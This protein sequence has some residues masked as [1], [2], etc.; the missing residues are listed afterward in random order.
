MNGDSTLLL[1]VGAFAGVASAFLYT[2]ANV[3]LK[4]A[5]AIDP[6]LVAAVKAL[7]T[8]ICLAPVVVWYLVA[9]KPLGTNYS[10]VPRFMVV[11]LIGQFVGNAAFQIAL[12]HIALAVAVP[13]TL[14][15]L[16]IGGGGL[17]WILLGE[18][19]SRG[20]WV[21]MAILILAVVVLSLGDS[22]GDG[23][24]E[25][26][27]QTTTQT[28]AQT[29]PQTTEQIGVQ[30]TVQTGDQATDQTGEPI[31]WFGALCAVATGAAYSLFGVVTRRTLNSGLSMPATLMISG[32]IGV[33]SLWSFCLWRLGFESVV[34][35]EN[36]QWI[37]MA[38]AGG[39]NFAAFVALSASLKY[40]PVVAVNL[41]NA[42][43]VAMAA[44]AGVYF[45]E[46]VITASVVSGITLTVVGLLVL[47][48]SGMRKQAIEPQVFTAEQKP[49]T[50]QKFAAR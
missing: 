44:A 34:A 11:A 31:P 2:A 28:T 13:I 15:T 50:E 48:I 14:G 22:G 29:G 49:A 16:I 19:I 39:F 32:S 36:D 5:V 27:E 41:I 1:R 21:A 3:Q 23:F 10:M 8:V 18:P 17:G 47:T 4:R 20:K 26:P 7:P 42:S 9:K 35:I 33:V 12:G 25:T 24:R 45:F 37:T 6:F 40:L 43:Q 30:T 46:E 38:W